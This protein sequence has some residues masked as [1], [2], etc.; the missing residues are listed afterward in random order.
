MRF[1]ITPR[2]PCIRNTCSDIFQLIDKNPTH[3]GNILMTNPYEFLINFNFWFKNDAFE[4][5]YIIQNNQS[6]RLR[7]YKKKLLTHLINNRDTTSN[8]VV[9]RYANKTTVF[10]PFFP[11]SFFCFYEWLKLDHIINNSYGNYLFIGDDEKQGVLESIIFY[12]ENTQKYYQKSNYD[13]WIIGDES[14]DVYEDEYVSI[15]HRHNILS[16]SYNVRYIKNSNMMLKYDFIAVSAISPMDTMT[17]WNSENYDLYRNMCYLTTAVEMLNDTGSLI[18]LL[19]MLGNS[20]WSILMDYCETHF[21][22]YSF[23]RPEI[24]NRF[25]PE[26]YL[27]LSGKK[28]VNN[29]LYTNIWQIL[30]RDNT[31]NIFYLETDENSK[32][33]KLFFDQSAKMLDELQNMK[34]TSID[35][36]LSS[37][38]IQDW[39]HKHDFI[40]V[41]E[42][43]IINDYIE[44]FSVFLNQ[45]YPPRKINTTDENNRHHSLI[46]KLYESRCK[47]NNIKRI[48]DT[49]PNRLFGEYRSN[50]KETY[51]TWET[52][53]FKL[54]HFRYLKST[55]HKL[56]NTEITTNAWTKLYEMI[57]KNNFFK[58]S[59]KTFHICEAPGG[60]ISAMNHYCVSND[61]Q[62]DWFAQSLIIGKTSLNDYYGI[63]RTYPEKWIYGPPD[64]MTGDIT[65]PEIIK[66]YI[67]RPELS[68]I[69]FMTA[70][71]GVACHPSQ[72]NEIESNMAKI[73]LGQVICIIGCLQ[74]NGNAVIKMFLPMVKALNISIVYLLSTAFKSIEFTKPK[75]SKSVNSEFYII[76]HEYQ[77]K[78]IIGQLD[79]LLAILKNRKT[80]CDTWL[81]TNIP[82]KF[83]K[84][85]TSIINRLIDNQISALSSCYY[86]YYKLNTTDNSIFP[87]TESKKWINENKITMINNRNHLIKK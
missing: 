47:L 87:D 38:K 81:Y 37:V 73:I 62:L 51:L 77:K 72:I 22:E 69:D 24:S 59:V 64:N 44:Y 20:S 54:D 25:N 86:H 41:K 34:M 29:K 13:C 30:Y 15:I 49:K 33:A 35:P 80:N 39:C 9:V 2:K 70:D 71:G 17:E 6:V 10:Q 40:L 28:P 53:S 56:Y 18:I 32:L 16:Q 46:I 60:F 27:F 65:D 67:A 45:I 1:R 76:A 85:Y 21:T 42:L 19:N 7:F 31:H 57:S 52:L 50:K 8:D 63:M 66:Y 55:L 74:D 4:I 75:T 26:I 82:K 78:N 12:H 11:E 84:E 43:K 58:K 3:I 83:M 14:Y 23:Y 5:K 68:N 61:I 79:E 36:Q 48:M